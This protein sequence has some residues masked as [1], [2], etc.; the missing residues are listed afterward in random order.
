MEVV[1]KLVLDDLK[2][3]LLLRIAIQNY[4]LKYIN[5]DEII[6]NQDQLIEKTKVDI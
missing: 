4:D 5:N 3:I 1:R 6:L 2:Q